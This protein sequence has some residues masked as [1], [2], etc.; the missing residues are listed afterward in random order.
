MESSSESRG[1]KIRLMVVWVAT[2]AAALILA[3][4]LFYW[5]VV[6]HTD[7]REVGQRWQLVDVPIPALRGM[8]LDRNGFVFAMDEYEFEIYATPRDI[9]YPKELAADLASVLDADQQTLEGLLSRTDK[10]SVCL[11]WDAPLAMARAVEDIKDDW[12]TSALGIGPARKRL[13]P[14]GSLASHL[15]GF[16]TYGHEVDYDAFYGVE[17]TYDR[18]LRGEAGSWGGSGDELDLSVSI[19]AS[20]VV[21]P[22]DGRDV[23]LTVDRTIQQMTE[24][25]LR[26]TLT[27]YGGQSGTIIVMDPR[28]GAILAMA[29]YP[30]YDP[31]PLLGQQIDED[32]FFNPAVSESYEPGSVFKVVTMAAA[33][34]SGT[35]GRYTTYYDGGQIYVGGHLIMNWDREAYGPTSM[36]DLLK[37]SLNVGAAT[38]STNMGPEVFYD[39]VERFGFGELT[40]VD[41]PY[42]ATGLLRLPG[43]GN[44]REGDLGTNSFGQGIAVTPIQMIRAVAAVANGGMLPTPYLVQ[45]IEEEGRIVEEFRPQPARQVITPWV[46]QELSEMLTEIVAGKENLEIPGYS[47]AGKTGT[48][49]IPVAGG[50]HPV[51]TIASFV[52]YAPAQDP[53]F[54]I[55]VK[56]DKPTASPWG[57]VVAVPAV[58][59]L[60][61]QL[62]RYLNIP[63]DDFRLASTVPA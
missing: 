55:L 33:L 17:E 46:A 62:F 40:G 43:D 41:L 10:P 31:N 1:S 28:T 44:W 60:A 59:S 34:D 4:R 5:Q 18:Q 57:S 38:L 54:I 26:N 32:L 27:E 47:I 9:R 13:Y 8:V 37:H 14:E 7:L 50:Y 24:D 39:Y 49:Q 35:V 48:A 21:L 52:A 45:R 19:G 30:T 2:V 16:V 11:V 36:T 6:R 29:S 63:P 12:G 61:E 51:D 3:G 23:V 53:A 58:R 20:S 42:E 15:L 56:I 25:E 22:R